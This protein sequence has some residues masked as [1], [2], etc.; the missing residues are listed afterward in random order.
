MQGAVYLERSVEAE[1][2]RKARTQAERHGH[3]RDTPRS[4]PVAAEQ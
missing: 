4:L 3:D 2:E 1:N